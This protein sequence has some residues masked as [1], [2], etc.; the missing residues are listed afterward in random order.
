[1]FEK[2]INLLESQARRDTPYA[3]QGAADVVKHCLDMKRILLSS[4]WETSEVLAQIIGRNEAIKSIG[5]TG[6]ILDYIHELQERFQKNKFEHPT[7]SWFCYACE[8]GRTTWSY[9]FNLFR[10]SSTCEDCN[11]GEDIIFKAVKLFIDNAYEPPTD[12]LQLI[13]QLWTLIFIYAQVAPDIDSAEAVFD[14]DRVAAEQLLRTGRI[15]RFGNEQ[16]QKSNLHLGKQIQNAKLKWRVQSF[17]QEKIGRDPDWFDDRSK[18]RSATLIGKALKV[19]A[20]PKGRQK[21]IENLLDELYPDWPPR[22]A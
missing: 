14:L 10:P 21:T 6:S 15:L 19:P 18:R 13:A 16:I 17:C 12:P 1:M 11:C 2:S 20:P 4:F 3:L 8:A 5:N 7:E 22:K 9:P